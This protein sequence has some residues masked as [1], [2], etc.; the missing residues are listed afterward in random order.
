MTDS[1]G[2]ALA[3]RG[4]RK[5]YGSQVALAGL[6]LSVPQRH[7]LRFPRAEWG[8]QDHHHAPADRPHPPRCGND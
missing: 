7:R 5:S 2:L 1:D 8:W 3:T 4:L 6:D